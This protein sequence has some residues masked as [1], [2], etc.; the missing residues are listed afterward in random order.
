[1]EAEQ[2]Q[3][4][5]TTLALSAK[6]NGFKRASDKTDTQPY[7]KKRRLHSY[8]KV[9]Q[10]QNILRIQCSSSLEDF[11]PSTYA[12]ERSSDPFTWRHLN[13]S[14][15]QGSDMM[16]CAHYLMYKLKCNVNFDWDWS[17]G[18]LCVARLCCQLSS[19]HLTLFKA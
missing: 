12:A 18:S 1:M 8:V 6:K 2:T 17:H 10:I 16:C 13:F 15:D 14:S 4:R 5:K 3:W 7:R 11:Q 19:Y 9:M